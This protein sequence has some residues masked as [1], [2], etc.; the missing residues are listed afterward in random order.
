MI[1]DILLRSQ[2]SLIE[3]AHSLSETLNSKLTRDESSYFDEFP[4]FETTMGDS[5]IAILGQEVGVQEDKDIYQ[6]HIQTEDTE[7]SI[8]QFSSQLSADGF[9][10]LN[11]G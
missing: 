9:E 10:V 8:H 2:L 1:F 7:F 11:D 3:L 4:A 6:I 5:H